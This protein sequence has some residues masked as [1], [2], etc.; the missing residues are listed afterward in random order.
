[1][2]HI[3]ILSTKSAGS[4]AVQNYFKKNYGFKTVTYTEHQEEETLYWTKVASILKKPQE[5]MYRSV[6]PLSVSKAVESLNSFFVE[7]GLPEIHCTEDSKQEDFEWFYYKLISKF[8]PRFIEKSPHHL[9]NESNLKLIA[10]FQ[11]RYKNVI[12]FYNIGLVRHPQAVL[13]SAWK[14]WKYLPNK[15]E[16]EWYVSYLNLLNWKISLN[17]KIVKYEILV[18][19][20]S[21]GESILKEKPLKFNFSFKK[22][23]VDKWKMD[24]QY[25]HLLKPATSEFLNNFGYQDFKL[26]RKITY[27]IELNWYS[28]IFNIKNQIKNF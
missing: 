22:G 28:A 21:F 16:Q 8:G 3:T 25:G 6:V 20:T 26:R 14:R 1:M 2:K 13:Y 15:F 7:N 10:D 12:E 17:M 5:S 23:S 18:N 9:Y 4:T 24:S 19:Q 27:L 11:N